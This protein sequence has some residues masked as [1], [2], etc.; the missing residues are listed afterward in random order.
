MD[1]LQGAGLPRSISS[2]TGFGDA[3]GEIGRD[4]DAMELAQMPDDLAGARATGVHRHD[5]VVEAQ[6]RRWYLA[7]SCGSNMSLTGRM[8]SPAR[9]GRSQS[10]PSSDHSRCGC[11]LP[12]RSPDDDPS[13]ALS[14]RS[15]RPFFRSSSSPLVSKAIFGSASARGASGMRGALAS[16]NRKPPSPSGPP[17]PPPHE[18]PDTPGVIRGKPVRATISDK[19]SPCPLD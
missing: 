15:A 9:S 10:S 1:R 6:K 16:C 19:A 4:I 7:M 12:L 8:G 17:W 18:I 11:C 3:I 13:P 14:A 2:S 5:L